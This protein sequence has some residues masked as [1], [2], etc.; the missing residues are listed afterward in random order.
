MGRYALLL[1]IFLM[2]G[3]LA[4]AAGAVNGPDSAFWE[5]MSV[6]L[7]RVVPEQKAVVSNSV[8]GSD[9]KPDRSSSLYWKGR[10][11]DIVVPKTELA[12]FN[13]ALQ[14]VVDGKRED[15]VKDFK[16]FLAQYP[17]SALVE[18]ARAAL[19]ELQGSKTP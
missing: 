12:D 5:A 2:L 11:A 19:S 18:D 9:L 14:A 3:S 4:Q 7:Q 16:A 6:R 17:K 10:E 1:V 15:A 8:S 13:L